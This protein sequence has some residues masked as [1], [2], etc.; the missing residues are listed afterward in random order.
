MK[1]Y[2]LIRILETVQIFRQI[3]KIWDKLIYFQ[4]L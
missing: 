2:E 4:F 1:G 3:K